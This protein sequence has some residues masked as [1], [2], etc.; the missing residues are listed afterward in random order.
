VPQRPQ[1]YNPNA[2]RR[3]PNEPGKSLALKD[4]PLS[5]S[6]ERVKEKLMKQFCKLE[7]FC[8]NSKAYV[9]GWERI[10][11]QGG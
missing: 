9:Q 11:G 7:G 6:Q 8:G 4:L 5:P 2:Y 1:D 3:I 10:F